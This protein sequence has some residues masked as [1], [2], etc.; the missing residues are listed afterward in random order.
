VKNLSMKI[1]GKK[2]GIKTVG[3]F[4]KV[5]VAGFGSREEAEDAMKSAGIEDFLVLRKS[6][7][8]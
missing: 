3:K 6:D 1:P 5:R 4:Y 8:H 2:V 7:G